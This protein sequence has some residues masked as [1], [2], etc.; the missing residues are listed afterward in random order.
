MHRRS[1]GA[2][3]RA[4]PHPAGLPLVYREAHELAGATL[5]GIRKD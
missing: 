2:S 5:T 3:D 4:R 1:L